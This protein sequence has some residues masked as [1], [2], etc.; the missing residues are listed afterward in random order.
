MK[1]NFN[2]IPQAINITFNSSHY[3]KVGLFLSFLFIFLY[4]SIPV[5]IV[6]G[7]S[8]EF[9]LSSTPIFELFLII[10]ISVLMGIIATM[11]LYSWKNGQKS[12]KS[13]ALGTT[14]FFSGAIASIFSAATCASCLSVLF[15][16]LGFGG[17][18]FLLEH[19]VEILII[20]A[21]TVL[22]ALF[23]LSNKIVK[24]CKTC[25]I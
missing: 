2:S 24:G 19:R 9:F 5:Y 8:Y 25:R 22:I 10:I 18:V 16:F 6:P 3:Q 23:F 21:A 1:I 12:K 14:G 17:I 13:I 4:I 15:S 20:S 7:N 11:Q